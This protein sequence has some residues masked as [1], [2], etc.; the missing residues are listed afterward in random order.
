MED[1]ASNG[2]AIWKPAAIAFG[3]IAVGACA[4]SFMLYSALA[5]DLAAAK[6]DVNVAHN[7]LENLRSELSSMEARANVEE[8]QQLLT[9]KAQVAAQVRRSLPIELTF[10]DAAL[11]SGKVALLHNLSDADLEVMLEVQRPASDEHVR[12]ALVINAHGTL[13]VGAAQGWHFAPG[14][15]VTLNNDKYR[16]IVRIVS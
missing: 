3:M 14:E 11:R 5:T 4:Y 10:H 15:I 7:E 16:P 9:R 6:N 13:Q 1:D 2:S 12:R 8:E